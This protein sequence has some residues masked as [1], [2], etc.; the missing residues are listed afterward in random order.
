[1]RKQA[2]ESARLLL[3][4]AAARRAAEEHAAAL[5]Q[6]RERL[7][8]TLRSIGDGVIATDADG[9]V[10]LLNPVAE[11]LTGWASADAVGQRLPSVFAIINEQS[12]RPVQDPVAQG[13]QEGRI[14]GV[15]KGK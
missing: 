1:V 5:W 2:E 11:A 3:E 10:T 6:E 7:R 9:K 14:V 15:A 4:E 13:L 8:V 12:R